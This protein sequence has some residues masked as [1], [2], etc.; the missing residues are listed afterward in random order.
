MSTRLPSRVATAL[1]LF[2]LASC[3]GFRQFVPREAATGEAPTGES[4]A[5]YA[6][7]NEVGE[8]LGDLRIWSH[9]AW[10]DNAEGD[11]DDYTV[12]HLGFELENRS[13]SSLE[14][15]P[16]RV[17]V[18]NLT[19]DG[20]GTLD[21]DPSPDVDGDVRAAPG[22]R[23]T[24]HF[25]FRTGQAVDPGRLQSFDAE[26]AVV[27]EQGVVTSQVTP[28]R[29]YVPPPRPA[30]WG[31]GWGYGPG[32]GWGYGGRFGRCGLWW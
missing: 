26:W 30:G 8:A 2:A 25:L 10:D 15:D 24:V 12:V 5:E 20:V 13:T 23:T 11:E 22:R 28:F 27:D 19:V 32:W 16:A 7:E 1:L 14:V 6:L 9:G 3:Q 31:P 21:L 4:A 29:A 17:A 18:R